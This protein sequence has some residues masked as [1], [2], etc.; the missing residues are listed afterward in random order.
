[1]A[2]QAMMAGAVH[3]FKKVLKFMRMAQNDSRNLC[4]GLLRTAEAMAVVL[5]QRIRPQTGPKPVCGMTNIRF[6]AATV[7]F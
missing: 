4:F 2:I 1:M 7:G 5:W 6:G 3:N